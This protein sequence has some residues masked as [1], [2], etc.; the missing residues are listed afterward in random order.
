[1]PLV[2]FN[3][4]PAVLHTV[5]P[6]LPS[7]QGLYQRREPLDVCLSASRRVGPCCGEAQGGVVLPI[8]AVGNCVLSPYAIHLRRYFNPQ[9]LSA[10]SALHN[11]G[12]SVYCLHHVLPAPTS[13]FFEA[14][15]LQDVSSLTLYMYA[16]GLA[17]LSFLQLLEYWR[18]GEGGCR[19]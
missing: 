8:S 2:A 7:R 17:C 9:Q 19:D 11:L 5:H 16:L 15:Q 4:Y 10:A 1:M 3:F 18:G 12:A 13:T 14:L 6:R